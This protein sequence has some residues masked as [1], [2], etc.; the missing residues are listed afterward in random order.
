MDKLVR[1]VEQ[2]TDER[3]SVAFAGHRLVEYAESER[4]CDVCLKPVTKKFLS[5]ASTPQAYSCAACK[6]VVHR[7]CQ[8]L[9]SRRCLAATDTGMAVEVRICPDNGLAA[10]E[11]RCSECKVDIGFQGAGSVFSEARV[12]DYLGR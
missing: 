10:Q 1:K 8:Q 9:I 11:Y 7:K 6:I 12:C 4:P 3:T 2:N 5:N